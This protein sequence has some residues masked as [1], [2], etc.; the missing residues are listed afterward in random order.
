MCEFNE[1]GQEQLYKSIFE[2]K[3]TL[4]EILRTSKH[5]ITLVRRHHQLLDRLNRPHP[6][7][8]HRAY[9]LQF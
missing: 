1:N 6:N 2:E 4:F 5:I 3:Y 8:L 7:N 9:A